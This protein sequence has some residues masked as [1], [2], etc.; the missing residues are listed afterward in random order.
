MAAAE[1]DAAE[2]KRRV[3]VSHADLGRALKTVD[4]LLY[5]LPDS[6][7][8]LAPYVAASALPEA[9]EIDAARARAQDESKRAASELEKVRRLTP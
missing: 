2:L 1:A 8:R 6:K 5:G 9:A 3:E 4:E 7:K